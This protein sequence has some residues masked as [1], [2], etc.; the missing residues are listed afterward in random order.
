[1][2]WEPAERVE[3]VMPN[4]TKRGLPARCVGQQVW[5]VR[6][7]L[8]RSDGCPIGSPS[9]LRGQQLRRQMIRRSRGLD[10]ISTQVDHPLSYIDDLITGFKMVKLMYRH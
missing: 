3:G 2:P 10:A 1:M 6:G 9:L 7:S 4:A 5:Y 8:M